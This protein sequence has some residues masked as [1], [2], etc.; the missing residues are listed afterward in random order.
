[1]PALGDAFQAFFHRLYIVVFER[2]DFGIAHGAA[3]PDAGVAIDIE[4]DVITL[5]R[6]GADD[7]QIGLIAGGEDHGM[8]H[9]IEVFQR[10]F[11]FLVALIGAVQH[12]AAGGARSEIG[13]RLFARLHHIGIEGHAH[14]IIGAEQDRFAPVA[15]GAGGAEHL[16]HHQ[17]ERVFYAAGQ[18]PFAHRNDVI[19]FGKQIL[20][21]PL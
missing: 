15:N 7:P 11:D 4:D 2:H 12:A 13:Q 21:V 5:A 9:G 19:E 10:L 3:V 8:I 20:A 6:D 14:V 16:F 1:M 18:Q 17:I